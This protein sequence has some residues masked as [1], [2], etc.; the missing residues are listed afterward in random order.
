MR[1]GR[2]NIVTAQDADAIEAVGALFTEYRAWLGD[3]VCSLR[4]AD[5]I[6]SL[7]GPYAAPTGRLLLARDTKGDPAGCVGVRALEGPAAEM[8]RLWV[9]PG[10]RR[11]GLGRAL[12]E[13][14]F[15]AARDLGYA[16]I[17]LTTLPDAMPAALAMYEGMGFA[18]TEP[19]TDHSHVG[20]AMRMF[21]LRLPL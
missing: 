11:L 21:Y 14:A 8:K 3:S 4:L 10:S 13:A 16:E 15:D 9:R 19:F 12:A 1:V 5:E 2:W 17:R 20:P 7:P 18:R 6:A